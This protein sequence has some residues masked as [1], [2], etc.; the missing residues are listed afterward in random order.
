MRASRRGMTQTE[1]KDYLN[2]HKRGLVI[3]LSVGSVVVALVLVLLSL[4]LTASRLNPVEQLSNKRFY[5]AAQI[6][7]DHIFYPIW[8]LPKQLQIALSDPDNRLLQQAQLSH[9]R[10]E[11]ARALIGKGNPALAMVALQKSQALAMQ[12]CHETLNESVSHVTTA[13]VAGLMI[14]HLQEVEAMRP[15]LSDQDATQVGQMQA[16][17][18]V[19]IS[20]LASQAGVNNW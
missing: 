7:P 4:R 1:L 13:T 18:E 9:D 17:T 2:R 12:T 11:E 5:I 19:L 8:R 15:L 20:Q 3:A 14:D 6:L 10:L 16:Q